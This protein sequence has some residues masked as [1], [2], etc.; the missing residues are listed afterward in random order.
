M[1]ATV[2]RTTTVS[3]PRFWTHTTWPHGESCWQ[4]HRCR[5]NYLSSGRCST[6]SCPPSSRAAAPSNSGSTLLSP[7]QERRWAGF[8]LESPWEMTSGRRYKLPFLSNVSFFYSPGGSEWRGNHL[9]YP[10]SPQSASPL[11]VTQIKEGSGGTASREGRFHLFQDTCQHKTD[12]LEPSVF[13]CCRPL[14]SLDQP[15]S[16][17]HLI[18][19]IRDQ[20]WHVV[21]SEGAV[22]AHAGQG[23]PAHWWIRERQEGEGKNTSALWELRLGHLFN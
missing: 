8:L 19:G 15:V 3:W 1:K 6:F 20:V 9:D 18:G 23:C 17:L 5:T 4:E 13:L 10:S 21:S 12:V 22:Q 11:P 7:W 2:W 16:P 14:L